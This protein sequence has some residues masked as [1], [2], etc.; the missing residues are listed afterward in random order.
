M[1]LLLWGDGSLRMGRGGWNQNQPPGIGE[2]R[3]NPDTPRLIFRQAVETLGRRRSQ[4]NDR[5]CSQPE[6]RRISPDERVADARLQRLP[7]TLVI[8]GVK[9]DLRGT[10]D[11]TRCA[12]E[13]GKSAGGIAFLSIMDDRPVSPQPN[14]CSDLDAG[15]KVATG[16]AERDDRLLEVPR[17]IDKSLDVALDEVAS[18]ADDRDTVGVHAFQPD[19]GGVGHARKHEGRRSSRSSLSNDPT[20][21]LLRKARHHK[22]ET[23]RSAIERQDIGLPPHQQNLDAPVD[24]GIGLFGRLEPFLP[25]AD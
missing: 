8:G 15:N 23:Q 21:G 4:E 14:A 11:M 12:P 22:R 13:P 25:E 2:F 9:P 24:S 5:G 20:I 1:K 3:G 19:L 7:A 10:T 18:D 16:A 17:H 6:V